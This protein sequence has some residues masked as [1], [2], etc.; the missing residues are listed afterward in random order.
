[1]ANS[2]QYVCEDG[3]LSTAVIVYTQPVYLALNQFTAGKC[4]IELHTAISCSDMIETVLI[5]FVPLIATRHF[6]KF[7]PNVNTTIH[8]TFCGL[9]QVN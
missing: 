1:M 7:A 8:F 2:V 9:F 5:L 4:E 3:L 6:I